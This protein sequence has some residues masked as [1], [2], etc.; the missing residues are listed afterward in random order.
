MK[1]KVLFLLFFV[2]VSCDAGRS[3]P[4]DYSKIH[5]KNKAKML[6]LQ[7]QLHLRDITFVQ[8][9][10]SMTAVEKLI[11]DLKQEIEGCKDDEAYCQ[12]FKELH[13]ECTI[14]AE[15]GQMVFLEMLGLQNMRGNLGGDGVSVEDESDD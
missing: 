9:M 2:Y 3:I 13:E 14:V 5:A 10:Q 8:C 1:T 11:D 12:L 4:I 15:N 7:T 6:Q